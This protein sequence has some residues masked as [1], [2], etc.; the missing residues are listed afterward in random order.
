MVGRVE[1]V[2]RAE[3]IEMKKADEIRGLIGQ[4]AVALLH[5]LPTF[6]DPFAHLAYEDTM[7]G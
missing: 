3:G 4:F 7:R 1:H 2:E 5:P 6:R